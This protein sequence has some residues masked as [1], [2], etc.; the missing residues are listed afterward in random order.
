L[1]LA[2]D[3]ALLALAGFAGGVLNAIAGGGSFITLATMVALG[4]PSIVAN[5]TSSIALFPGALMSAWTYRHDLPTVVG[6]A[7]PVIVAVSFAGS[8]LGAALLLLTTQR[9]FDAIVPWLL[10][11]ATLIFALGPQVTPILRRHVHYGPVTLLSIQFL[12]AIYGGYFGGAMGIL[13]LASFSLFGMTDF[14]SMNALKTLLAGL[15]NA[16]AVAIFIVAGKIA[17]SP[18]VVMM[19]AGVAGGWGGAW[20]AKRMNPVV[21]RYIAIALAAAITVAFFVR[22]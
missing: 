15:L 11:G 3:I 18:G 20:G 4:I 6:L 12:I 9:Q 17:W 1:H 13:M 8:A 21:L 2:L 16:I 5:A 7:T 10:L 14:N 19:V 22:R